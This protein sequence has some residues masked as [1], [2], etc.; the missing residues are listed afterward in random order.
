MTVSMKT[1]KKRFPRIGPL[2]RMYSL[3]IRLS[4]Q[5]TRHTNQTNAHIHLWTKFS[6]PSLFLWY[7]TLHQ[8]YYR[9]EI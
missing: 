2:F 7:H 9:V 1:L 3:S 4:L 6:P 5:H 8:L